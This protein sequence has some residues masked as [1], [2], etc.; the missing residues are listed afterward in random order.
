MKLYLV[1]LIFAVAGCAAS[2]PDGSLTRYRSQC[3]HLTISY[4]LPTGARFLTGPP[5]SEVKFPSHR[6]YPLS[7]G[8]AAVGWAFDRDI[9]QVKIDVVLE[10]IS[11]PRFERAGPG[12]WEA[13]LREERVS[14]TSGNRVSII[15]DSI[16][17]DWQETVVE[18]NGRIKARSFLRPVAPNTLILLR[19][20]FGD[21]IEDPERVKA[22][23][24]QARM[25]DAFIITSANATASS[26]SSTK[27]QPD[28]PPAPTRGK[29]P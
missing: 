9:S 19:L 26:D 21:H 4:E 15:Q 13:I 8:I 3:D 5:A 2:I 28:P 23:T 10:K 14:M 1:A 12:E 11:G 25:R 17:R 7:G 22:L 24:V 16:G 27:R 29:G 20:N 18:A 6:P